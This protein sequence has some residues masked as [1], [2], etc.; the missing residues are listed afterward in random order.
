MSEPAVVVAEQVRKAIAGQIDAANPGEALIQHLLCAICHHPSYSWNA[1]TGSV[2]AVTITCCG[3]IWHRD[4]IQ[5]ALALRGNCPMCREVPTG[6]KLQPANRRECGMLGTIQVKCPQKCGKSIPFD[7]LHRHVHQ[8]DGC[9]MSQLRCT[10][11]GC[12]ATF[13]R[14]DAVQH[15][16]ECV[17]LLAPCGLCGADVPRGLHQEHQR[18]VC[19]MAV[20][21]C[22]FC[23]ADG[24]R[25][26]Q[27]EAHRTEAC[28][29]FVPMRVMMRMFQ[30][31]KQEMQT[32]MQTQQDA[33]RRQVQT[34]ELLLADAGYEQHTV[35]LPRPLGDLLEREGARHEVRVEGVDSPIV[36]FNKGGQV[37]S[38]PY[39]SEPGKTIVLRIAGQRINLGFRNITADEPACIRIDSAECPEVAGV[40][41]KCPERIEDKAVWGK[42][43]CRIMYDTP[44]GRRW[45]V[46]TTANATRQNSWAGVKLYH[47][48]ASAPPSPVRQAF[49][50]YQHPQLGHGKQALNS[51][52]T[53]VPQVGCPLANVAHETE[54]L[55][56]LLPQ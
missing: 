3:Q 31:F 2:E 22:E 12:T 9:T 32:Q 30:D 8:P 39:L 45:L 17:H 16:R 38:E 1:Q 56:V 15:K 5:Q 47:S 43:E 53:A 20:V 4:C 18:S 23:K 27:M 25:R 35:Q 19:P 55:V 28:T 10:N 26:S 21:S 14:R 37:F 36:L 11:E 48:E 24:I 46:S 34:Q 40:Y 49:L 29:G 51:A 52:A 50:T 6:N 54:I 41:T 42:G 44:F 7:Q 33:L 13:L